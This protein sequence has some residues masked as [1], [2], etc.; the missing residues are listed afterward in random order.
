LTEKKQEQ[1]KGAQ[2]V[3]LTASITFLGEDQEPLVVTRV[4]VDGVQETVPFALVLGVDGGFTI[5]NVPQDADVLSSYSTSLM[6]LALGL[7]GRVLRA[8]KEAVKAPKPG[9]PTA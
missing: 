7:A 5:A 8:A 2:S 1:P 9:A 4:T 6:K 3:V